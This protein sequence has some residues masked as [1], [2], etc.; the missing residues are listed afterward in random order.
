MI[1]IDSGNDLH[2]FIGKLSLPL[3]RF[4]MGW[5][6]ERDDGDDYQTSLYGSSLPVGSL[7]TVLV[8]ENEEDVRDK[9]FIEIVQYTDRKETVFIGTFLPTDGRE[10]AD[11]IIPGDLLSTELFQNYAEESIQ[12]ITINEG[13]I[14]NG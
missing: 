2:T 6:Q 5:I 7:G 3:Y 4:I 13:G 10:C 11:I 12:I 8:A 9:N 14:A 1:R